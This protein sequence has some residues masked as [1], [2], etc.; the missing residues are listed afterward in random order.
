MPDGK[1]K[2]NLI[3]HNIITSLTTVKLEV[4]ALYKQ[5]MA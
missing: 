4:H 2:D 5:E 3:T 1:K